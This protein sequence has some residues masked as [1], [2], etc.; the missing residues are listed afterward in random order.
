MTYPA[1]AG[2]VNGPSG[3]VQANGSTQGQ[4]P[5]FGAPGPGANVADQTPT[6]DTATYNFVHGI[7]STTEMLNSTLLNVPQ[8]GLP[9]ISNVASIQIAGVAQGS[10]AV[11]RWS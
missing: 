1:G 4:A 10:L 3:P 5:P 7:E 6:S 2:V 11:N 9:A 8:Q